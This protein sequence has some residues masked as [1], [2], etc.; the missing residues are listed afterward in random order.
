MEIDKEQLEYER[1]TRIIYGTE[2]YFKYTRTLIYSILVLMAFLIAPI[3]VFAYD[4]HKE[5]WI[6]FGT[7]PATNN[8][9]YGNTAV[10]SN[11]QAILFTNG[12]SKLWPYRRF[13][14]DQYTA[15]SATLTTGHTYHLD[16]Q[17]TGTTYEL[18]LDG[19]LDSTI[20]TS[21]G[22]TTFDFTQ[23][24]WE[25]YIGTWTCYEED[26]DSE[27]PEEELPE[28][29]PVYTIPFQQYL[30]AS[31]T[32]IK[33]NS[34]GTTTY[35]CTA[36]STQLDIPTFHDWLFVSSVIIFLLSFVTWGYFFSPFKSK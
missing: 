3:F 31:S 36:T 32:C 4:S 2:K 27:P 6:N 1:Q 14:T 13:N 23:G 25:C 29:A 30:I 17:K 26:P 9:I 15:G 35:A 5:V 19:V 33:T 34:V 8:N 10:T 16:W 11:I 21:A 20:N 18:Y 28:I 12:D 7:V 24:T 22:D